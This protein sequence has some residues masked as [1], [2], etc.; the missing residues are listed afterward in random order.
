[1]NETETFGTYHPVVN[2]VFFGGA[3]VFGMLSVH[4][5]FVAVSV[6]TAGSMYLSLKKENGRFWRG[7]IS[8]FAGVSF[9]NPFFNL[10]GETVFFTYFN[11]RIYTL[12][13]LFHGMALGGMF[14]AVIIW[15]ASYS[16]IMTSDKFLYCF[17]KLSPAFSLILTMVL[18]LVPQYQRKIKQISDARKCIGKSV[19]DGT[20]MEKVKEGITI[21]SVLASLAL[22]GGIVTADSMVSRGHG[23]GNRT[24]FSIYQWKNKDTYLLVSMFALM[25]ITAFCMINGGAFVQYTPNL[26]MSGWENSYTKTGIL[27]YGIFLLIPTILNLMEKIAWYNLKSKI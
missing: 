4:P 21:V 7:M 9:L 25:G 10:R 14:V 2:F 1:M 13:A 3:V 27:C 22:E 11:G 16:V 20:K 19:T 6:I 12:E 26:Y 5:M 24:S 23:C 17:G 18:R 8:V 15:F